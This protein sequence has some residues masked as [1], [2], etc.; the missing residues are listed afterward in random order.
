MKVGP[1]PPKVKAAK[2]IETTKRQD[3]DADDDAIQEFLQG[4]GKQVPREAA[5][6]LSVAQTE[7]RNAYLKGS[8]PLVEARKHVQEKWTHANLVSNLALIGLTS[9]VLIWCGLQSANASV[10]EEI[11]SPVG[12]VMMFCGA[13]MLFSSL[14][15]AY[16]AIR[17]REDL[18]LDDDGIETPGQ[19]L[20]QVYFHLAFTLNLVILPISIITLF[21]D[22]SILTA[23][24]YGNTEY[25]AR[26]SS[27]VSILVC[28][29]TLISLRP[30]IM[31]V[32]IYE[33]AQSFLESFS[34]ILVTLGIVG[35]RLSFSLLNYA[36]VLDDDAVNS[37]PL[38]AA[39]YLFLTLCL[40]LIILSVVGFGAA[41]IEHVPLLKA[42]AVSMI[43][44][45]IAILSLMIGLLVADVNSAILGSCR[46]VLQIMSYEWWQSTVSCTKYGGTAMGAQ[47][48]VYNT[49]T[50]QY[51]YST[52]GIGDSANCQNKSQ[53]AFAWEFYDPTAG[54]TNSSNS[55]V[56][57]N[58]EGC[59]NFSCCQLLSNGITQLMSILIFG[60]VML[61]LCLAIALRSDIWLIRHRF[62][63]TERVKRL[64]KHRA[65]ILI[66][67][68]LLL[69]LAAIIIIGV[70]VSTGTQRISPSEI[71]AS[72]DKDTY[73]VNKTPIATSADVQSCSNGLRDGNETDIDC[74]G[75]SNNGGC[76]ARCALGRK[77]TEDSDCSSSH[78]NEET[79][80]CR[81]ETFLEQCTNGIRDG[82]ETSIDC[83]G[84]QC[85][86]YLYSAV[87]GN[88]SYN[89]YNDSDAFLCPLGAACTNDADCL[90]QTC[91]NGTCISCQDGIRNGDEGDVDC[92]SAQCV[93]YYRHYPYD[94]P[95][96]VSAAGANITA[97]DNGRCLDGSTCTS[98][99]QCSSG[100]CHETL[101]I[102][103]S[104]SNG[105]Q[106]GDE[107]GIDCGGQV[108]SRRCRVGKGC[109]QMYDCQTQRCSA[110][111]STG[112]CSAGVCET[113]YSIADADLDADI[114]GSS[115]AY[116]YIVEVCSDGE[117]SETETDIDCG[118]NLCTTI[119][120]TCDDG[121]SCELDRDCDSNLCLSG[122]CVS[123]ENNIVDGNETDVDCGGIVC[124][125]RCDYDASCLS[126]SDCIDDAFCW[127]QVELDAALAAADYYNVTD[128][129]SEIYI[130]DVNTCQ[131]Y[132]KLTVEYDPSATFTYGASLSTIYTQVAIPLPQSRATSSSSTSSSE[133]E[134][135]E[136]SSDDEST[137]RRSL[138]YEHRR[139]ASASN[140]VA[141]RTDVSSLTEPWEMLCTLQSIFR[142]E[143]G[144]RFVIEADN[145]ANATLYDKQTLI[146]TRGWGSYA[147]DVRI[148]PT[149]CSPDHEDGITITRT[150]STD[151]SSYFLIY[152]SVS[153]ATFRVAS[154][155]L[156]SGRVLSTNGEPVEGA[157]VRLWSIRTGDCA[158]SANA[159]SYE[160]CTD[161]CTQYSGV[162]GSCTSPCCTWYE[163]EGVAT[164]SCVGTSAADT[165]QVESTDSDGY[166][167]ISIPEF[168]SQDSDSEYHFGMAITHDDYTTSKGHAFNMEPGGIVEL[169][170]ISLA[171]ANLNP[172]GCKTYAS[173]LLATATR[174]CKNPVTGYCIENTLSCAQ[175]LE[176]MACDNTITPNPTSFP[177]LS[178]TLNPTMLPTKFPTKFPTLA[179]TQSPTM[180]PTL[181][182]TL[183][184]TDSPTV[185]PTAAPT[186]P[187]EAPTQSPSLYP[188]QSP[189]PPT[190]KP[191]SSPTEAPTLTPTV[192][193]TDT[194]TQSPTLFPTN[195][196]TQSPTDAPTDAPTQSPT[197]A[198][199]NAPTLNPTD[200]PTES[201][202][203]SPT[204]FP[205]NAPTDAP[206]SAPT[207]APTN[208]PTDAP[209]NAPTQFPTL[210]PSSQP[211]LSPTLYPTEF[212]TLSPTNSP[213][214]SP[215]LDPTASPTRSPTVSPTHAPT[216]YPTI[217]PTTYRE[218]FAEFSF[219]SCKFTW[220]EDA[221]DAIQSLVQRVSKSETG[222]SSF[223]SLSQFRAAWTE[224]FSIDV[225]SLA[226]C[227]TIKLS[228]LKE[229]LITARCGTLIS[230]VSTCTV[231]EVLAL[232]DVYNITMS[233]SIVG[234]SDGYLLDRAAA[235]PK[236]QVAAGTHPLV[237]R[238]RSTS[239]A[240]W[241]D[242]STISAPTLIS[243][244]GTYTV[245]VRVE[246][247]Y[248]EKYNAKV[249]AI[250]N[251]LAGLKLASSSYLETL[252]CSENAEVNI[253]PDSRTCSDNG[254]CCDADKYAAAECPYLGACYC[255]SGYI[256]YDC[257]M[258][259]TTRP[260]TA[261]T[262]KCVP[263]E[264]IASLTGGEY[265][266]FLT[267]CSQDNACES[268][269]YLCEYEDD[270]TTSS[271]AACPDGSW[272][273]VF[274]Q[275]DCRVTYNLGEYIINAL[276]ELGR[277]W[278]YDIAGDPYLYYELLDE[279]VPDSFDAYSMMLDNWSSLNKTHLINQN[280][281]IYPTEVDMA[282]KTNRWNYANYDD[283]VGFPRDA[284]PLEQGTSEYI[285]KYQN[286]WAKSY[287]GVAGRKT[288][289]V[290][291][292]SFSICVADELYFTPSDL[293]GSSS[294]LA[295][296]TYG[297]TG[298][299]IDIQAGLGVEA[300]LNLYRGTVPAYENVE[301]IYS[302]DADV[303]A[304]VLGT[305][306]LIDVS[307]AGLTSC[308]S[309][310][311]VTTSLTKV[312]ISNSTFSLPDLEAGAYTLVVSYKS[313]L[314]A[315]SL[316][317]SATAV[318]VIGASEFHTRVK[319]FTVNGT[320]ELDV[321]VAR[322][323][324][325][326]TLLVAFEATS[327]QVDMSVE[328]EAS[329][330]G[331]SC[332]VSS[333]MLSDDACS[334]SGAK[335]IRSDDVL[336]SNGKAMQVVYFSQFRSTVYKFFV[337]RTKPVTSSS[338]KKHRDDARCG[339][340]YPL[341][342]GE[343][344][345]CPPVAVTW[346]DGQTDLRPCCHLTM[347]ICG[348]SNTFCKS[349][350]SIDYRRFLNDT[351]MSQTRD[352]NYCN[353]PDYL[354]EDGQLATCPIDSPC[355]GPNT[356]CGALDYHCSS[357][358][359]IDYR[360]M[361]EL[362][363]NGTTAE[364]LL[365]LQ[366]GVDP[367]EESGVVIKVYTTSGLSQTFE[368]ADPTDTIN[369]LDGHEYEDGVAS[370]SG[371]FYRSFCIDAS[372]GTPQVHEFPSPRYFQWRGELT[373]M[374]ESCPATGNCTYMRVS[375][376]QTLTSRSD[377]ITT[378]GM[379]GVY[380]KRYASTTGYRAY[381]GYFI[382]V[383]SDCRTYVT[384]PTTGKKVWYITVD[385]TSDEISP[386]ICM[387]LCDEVDDC[388]DVLYV[389]YVNSNTQETQKK[390]R[391][392]T[393]I[394]SCGG[395]TTQTINA[396]YDYTVY[397]KRSSS[398]SAAAWYTML[399]T[400][401]LAAD[402]QIHLY[403]DDAS[404]AWYIDSDL[405]PSTGYYATAVALSD[406]E[407][408]PSSSWKIVLNFE[409]L[410]MY[411]QI[412]PI[413]IAQY[414]DDCTLGS[415]FPSLNET[416]EENGCPCGTGSSLVYNCYNVDC[417]RFPLRIKGEYICLEANVYRSMLISN[418]CDETD[419]SQFFVF[420]NVLNQLEATIPSSNGTNV[421]YVVYFD[422]YEQFMLQEVT[423]STQSVD[424]AVHIYFTED[425]FICMVESNATVTSYEESLIDQRRCI[426][427]GAAP[428]DTPLL[429]DSS[430]ADLWTT[431]TV[432]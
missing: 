130:P 421:S 351:W 144:N 357:E 361:Y 93:D 271:A 80:V 179:P 296:P 65:R 169:D 295:E 49:T 156:I 302:G 244:S 422:E 116:N 384:N 137:R 60:L 217:R 139:L 208:T 229:T 192:A 228:K 167:E 315:T 129:L 122:T 112:T 1:E 75:D 405:I 58:P 37:K 410:Q 400:L 375:G 390:C 99:S 345:Q 108:C 14:V 55:T 376:L 290:S 367:L 54:V 210:S 147:P 234:L 383:D 66:T 31:I 180:A 165:S 7:F 142:V 186:D 429:L 314:A 387:D 90:S 225:T 164:T 105:I 335:L 220:M 4:I 88:T 102:C 281:A 61:I 270:G 364:E 11:S 350:Y 193:P 6:R 396:A 413:T 140:V 85:R 24:V 386:Q 415:N 73:A 401:Y 358:Y 402:E 23:N 309:D 348:L 78:C 407:V 371:T 232:D 16:G 163:T 155:T 327:L 368:L 236:F 166:F 292:F 198:P 310:V 300:T 120:L 297:V 298:N 33:M 370:A 259:P 227:G 379:N 394:H 101:G 346:S 260:T 212:P 56:N 414:S 304:V 223:A 322:V 406:S 369:Y 417:N 141:G 305:S 336:Q 178:P 83:G 274:H 133:D 324:E 354:S 110:S 277:K 249:I 293:A 87:N 15:G 248:A 356:K 168:V 42:H 51:V 134:D 72:L 159:S 393:S 5:K 170:D 131:P 266:V 67:L 150:D 145:G 171:P 360:D 118:G 404:Q 323:L 333:K 114:L 301:P 77:C 25:Y 128:I 216:L 373:A 316:G 246:N 339:P 36:Q 103:V 255:N 19:Y 176:Y 115:A 197:D 22:N 183:K 418:M 95:S 136:E 240:C 219:E 247:I 84:G 326:G 312:A 253:C 307:P 39:L 187:T 35:L 398:K 330:E 135:V 325:E 431:F 32:T 148:Y 377:G 275:K 365:I 45:I 392:H 57:Y 291:E 184:P 230:E 254:I 44:L 79:L 226:D 337:S 423:S 343:A 205:T 331:D 222:D 397:Q 174:L 172:C 63:Q 256:G 119:G 113:V 190:Q 352:D 239:G 46:S 289:V 28:L 261:P 245:E 109:E 263:S 209:T 215:T 332:R 221:Y 341:S 52:S 251:A 267:I 158:L 161:D 21:D 286:K 82:S 284:R 329:E 299:I 385:E 123:C 428:G 362:W 243:S 86:S 106:D 294:S 200:A 395:L 218:P 38:L 69:L 107:T 92:G 29:L 374:S 242:L 409:K 70:S 12:K 211:T 13:I 425:E 181:S 273:T 382:A 152:S 389:E 366:S 50:S 283:D 213:T 41:M 10:D 175:Y 344:A 125:T 258:Q 303:Q 188:T 347:G 191:T 257:S 53:V 117:V 252:P 201:P 207:D 74:G 321:N 104:C 340:N 278:R 359:S 17:V 355:C 349:R 204:N 420:N 427:L 338:Y 282:N 26:I 279:E 288:P 182:P 173:S 403:K 202:T 412:R 185:S 250:Q 416:L 194:P 151:C 97:D 231:D 91:S 378:P 363:A 18:E 62:R 162:Y 224:V 424:S 30:T 311:N 269:P 138:R 268:N 381:P 111:C 276:F 206:T 391:F 419:D 214:L 132:V 411:R 143:D 353:R 59:L 149:N 203:S 313:G 328:F 8:T 238:L 285:Q 81:E 89:S 233:I 426:F 68:I 27:G 399:D 160:D 241:A 287:C 199:T 48:E 342:S 71:I 195:A 430:Y 432:I 272:T 264:A 43:I 153:V 380:V 94:K 262:R 9:V 318:Q 40:V 96:N 177:T 146:V 121:L 317:Y 306:T 237:T 20:L 126:T 98:P 127:T 308:S 2:V 265:E 100:V 3:N 34:L 388:D 320:T 372:L 76:A 64:S 319:M 408:P 196:P 124:A 189:T 235:S 47:V 154:S 157:V 280:F 334:C